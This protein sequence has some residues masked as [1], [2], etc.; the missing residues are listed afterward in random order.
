MSASAAFLTLSLNLKQIGILCQI[1]SAGSITKAAKALGKNHSSICYSLDVLE[2]Q[3]GVSL[4]I[5][6]QGTAGLKLTAAGQLLV[7]QFGPVFRRMESIKEALPDAER[8]Q[9][10]YENADR[11][12]QSVHSFFPE[13]IN[14]Q[15]ATEMTVMECSYN[16]RECESITNQI[17]EIV[18]EAYAAHG[19]SENTES[20]AAYLACV[21]ADYRFEVIEQKS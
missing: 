10:L 19:G 18:D 11:L 20:R 21:E 6:K 9:E 7:N 1:V 17:L 2:R 13:E 12:V 15:L 5:R 16:L 14:Q 8:C 3:S 4:V